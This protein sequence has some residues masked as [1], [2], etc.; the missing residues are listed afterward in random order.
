MDIEPTNLNGYLEVIKKN[1]SNSSSKDL[2]LI[3]Y[4]II[5]DLKDNYYLNIAKTIE[6][7]C[8]NNDCLFILTDILFGMGTRQLIEKI[9]NIKVDIVIMIDINHQIKEQLRENSIKTISINC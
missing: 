4:T 9:I 3:I 1:I 6:S 5:P 7:T 8:S 2:P